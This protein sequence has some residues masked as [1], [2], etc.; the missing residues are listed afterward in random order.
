[1][2][3]TRRTDALITGGV[4]ALGL[5]P[6]VAGAVRVGQL[7]NHVTATPENA[8]FVAMP[9][10][11]I[12]HILAA[13]VYAVGGA[14]QFAP[15]LRRL[16]PTWHRLLGALLIPCGFVV[17]LSAL[18]MAQI[19]PNGSMRGPHASDFDGN[20]LFVIRL[21]VGS[22]MLG[23]L[24]LGV[25]AICDRDFPRH[26]RWMLRAYALAMGAGTQVFTHIPWMVFPGI[27][28]EVAR[29]LCMLAGW[30]INVAVA[31]WI[32]ARNER[33]RSHAMGRVPDNANVLMRVN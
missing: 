30:L 32:I 17:A 24:S 19:Y 23:F 16:R 1:M 6:V 4:L 31:E 11:V 29:A 25:S 10:P 5:V 33:R 28:S 2:S 12:F 13:T 8:R 21:L 20:F 26:G 27:R 18:W 7:A 14:L 3:L 15:R 22:A 9:T